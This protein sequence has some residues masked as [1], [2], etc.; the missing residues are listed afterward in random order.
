LDEEHNPTPPPSRGS[1]NGN[2][3][4]RAT[5]SGGA[6]RRIWPVGLADLDSPSGRYVTSFSFLKAVQ[7]S[8]TKQILLFLR[9]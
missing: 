8:S 1:T 2:S 5:G 3:M 7:P 6:Q 9:Q 4:Y